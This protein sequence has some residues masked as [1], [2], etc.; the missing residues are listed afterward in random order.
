MI[1][2]YNCQRTS[3]CLQNL[4]NLLKNYAIL[5]ANF[6]AYFPSSMYLM[7]RTCLD[8]TYDIEI[9]LESNYI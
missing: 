1:H 4:R 9:I 2:H 7:Y 6:C 3:K 5:L 8:M